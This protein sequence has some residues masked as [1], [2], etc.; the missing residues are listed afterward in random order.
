MHTSHLEAFAHWAYS[1]WN[2]LPIL[3]RLLLIQGIGCCPLT[4]VRCAFV[5]V[6]KQG[7]WLNDSTR[8]SLFHWKQWASPFLLYRWENKLREGCWFVKIKD[9]NREDLN[10]HPWLLCTI[11]PRICTKHPLSAR[12]S[13]RWPCTLKTEAASMCCAL[14]LV[15]ICRWLSC[16]C[17]LPLP[18]PGIVLLEFRTQYRDL[19]LSLL[20]IIVWIYP[21]VPAYWEPLGFWHYCSLF[22]LCL[23]ACL[24]TSLS[25]GP[26]QLHPCH[27]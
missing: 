5:H 3:P 21:K 16:P 22:L 4:T 25:T 6:W 17:P 12:F 26:L 10:P 2:A 27:Q 14:L 11:I 18:L 7:L 24:P 9:L 13:A 19:P 20:N 1:S 15:S 23:P 8:L